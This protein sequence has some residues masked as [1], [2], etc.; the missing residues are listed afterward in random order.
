MNANYNKSTYVWGNWLSWKTKCVGVHFK[1][2]YFL[3]IF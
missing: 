1:L 3:K 2:K